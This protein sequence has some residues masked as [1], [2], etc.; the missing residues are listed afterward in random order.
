MYL[1]FPLLIVIPES[2]KNGGTR[3]NSGPSVVETFKPAFAQ[4]FL[5]WTIRVVVTTSQPVA[6][7]YRQVVD[8]NQAV[9][10]EIAR[11]R[12]AL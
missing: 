8:R 9:S 12:I 10:I 11:Q 7:H 4:R 2:E 3:L 1:C 5:L 6:R